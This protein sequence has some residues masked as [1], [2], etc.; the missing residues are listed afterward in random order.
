MQNSELCREQLASVGKTLAQATMEDFSKIKRD[1]LFSFVLCRMSDGKSIRIQG[2][3]KTKGNLQQAESGNEN[4]I[5]VAFRLRESTENLET[6]S[7][8]NIEELRKTLKKKIAVPVGITVDSTADLSK[9]FFDPSKHFFETAKRI[10]DP[11][12]AHCTL[13][14]DNL[15]NNSKFQ[16]KLNGV[17]EILFYRLQNHIQTRIDPNKSKENHWVWRF[18]RPNLARIAAIMI[19]FGHIR[20]IIGTA[21]EDADVPLLSNPQNGSFIPVDASGMENMEGSYLYYSN[22]DSVMIRSGKVVGVGRSL[23][24]R[25]KEHAANAMKQDIHQ[26]ESSFYY[27]YP[28][29]DSNIGDRTGMR[30]E[31]EDLRAYSA[32]SFDREKLE[33]AI[34]EHGKDTSLFQWGEEAMEKIKGVQFPGNLTLKEK[35]LHMVGYLCEL[36]YDLCISQKANVSRKPGFE[37]PLGEFQ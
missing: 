31:F 30:S 36:C 21:K 1:L 4:L 2:I 3:P 5:R 25:C 18:V 24:T 33:E 23:S 6:P 17:T 8:A 29:K 16:N 11:L 32:L 26:L 34:Y 10:F 37:T 13:L 27:F 35:Q 22:D 7:T 20:N 14:P 12:D 19:Q 15:L 9:C 28:S